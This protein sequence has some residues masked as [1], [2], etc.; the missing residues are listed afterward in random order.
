[1]KKILLT[2]I[3]I[4][5]A[6]TLHAEPVIITFA[7]DG[8]TEPDLAGYKLYQSAVSNNYSGD[9]VAIVLGNTNQYTHQTD[10]TSGVPYYFVLTAFDNSDLESSYSN[11]VTHVIYIDSNAPAAPTIFNIKNYVIIQ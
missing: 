7:W 1:M 11:E 3:L 8:N 5:F 10:M 9:P 4:L 2:I 6:T